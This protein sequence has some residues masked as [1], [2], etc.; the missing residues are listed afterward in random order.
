[1]M[2]A[3]INVS[4]VFDFR[5]LGR[6]V[7]AMQSNGSKEIAGR[8]QNNRYVSWESYVKSQAEKQRLNNVCYQV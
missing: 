8:W 5:T 1:M 4:L 3:T 7:N 6:D 2:Q